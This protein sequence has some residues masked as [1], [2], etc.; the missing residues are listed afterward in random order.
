MHK[1]EEE[2]DNDS[3]SSACAKVAFDA[4]VEIFSII[5]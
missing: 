3:Q 2:E 1:W 5:S 4:M